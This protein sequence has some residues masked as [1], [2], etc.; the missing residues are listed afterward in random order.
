M[1]LK[2]FSVFALALMIAGIGW[3]I[4]RHEL[5][6]RRAPALIVQGLAVGL[7]ISARLTFGRRSFHAA[8]NPTAGGLVT[9]GPYRWL[10]HPIYAAVLYFCWAAAIDH[11]SVQAFAAAAL[12]TTGA[13]IRMYAE[14]RLLGVMYPDYAAYSARTSRLIPFCF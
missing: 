10:R 12:V 11:H 14:E 4:T 5:L 1:T 13:A 7:M 6:A 9:T 3:L 8:A 2:S